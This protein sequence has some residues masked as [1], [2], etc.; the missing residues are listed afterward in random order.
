MNTEELRA[1]I[2]RLGPWHHDMRVA[3]GIRTGEVVKDV[4][5]PPS[6]GR[7]TMIQPERWIGRL[8][9][10]VFPDGLNGRSFL[11][12][13]CNGG[14]YLLAAAER[15]AGRCFGLDVRDHWID[16]ARFVARETG[17]RGVEFT[18][19]DLHTLPEMELEP[20]DVTLFM[21]IFYHL[22][23]PIASLRMVADHTKELLVLNTAY[24]PGGGDA[25]RLN[26]ESETLVMSGVHRLAWLPTSEL[27]LR[28]ILHWCGFP[29]VRTTRRL[30]LPGGHFHRIE[31]FAA[32]EASTF[33]RFDVLRPDALGPPRPGLLRRVLNRVRRR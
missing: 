13:A 5:Y 31:L 6:Y 10:E 15:G 23:D 17:A 14:G 26:L 29:H 4:A 16:Q 22:P 21:G 33:S 32:R 1:E 19:A 11:D 12:C 25:L 30:P 3:P 18:T 27:V 2:R 28:E 7:V 20:F 24:Q 8:I 9:E